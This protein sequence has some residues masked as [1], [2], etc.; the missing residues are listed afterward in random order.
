MVEGFL[1]NPWTI[2]IG[3]TVIATL[4]LK[5]IFGIDKKDVSKKATKEPFVFKVAEEEITYDEK[6]IS[7]KMDIVKVVAHDHS[8]G[9]RSEY[10]WMDNR[11]P[12]NK[13][14]EQSLM[15]F[16]VEALGDKKKVVTFDVHRIELED[17]RE[18]KIYFEIDSFFADGKPASFEPGYRDQKIKDIYSE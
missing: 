9:I 12:N 17:G 3:G 16:E 4:I 2:A 6:L 15:K 7:L 8:L 11:Y 14:F 10:A 13:K 18:K 1:L 5:H